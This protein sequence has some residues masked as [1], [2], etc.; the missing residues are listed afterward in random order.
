MFVD[1]DTAPVERLLHDSNILASQR[2][3]PLSQIH[4]IFQGIHPRLVDH[5]HA[6]CEP[7]GN[8]GKQSGDNGEVEP[9]AVM[10]SRVTTLRDRAVCA[11]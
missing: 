6:D 7:E 1:F 10:D 9:G 2:G 4:A 3:R 5:R 11:D 8:R